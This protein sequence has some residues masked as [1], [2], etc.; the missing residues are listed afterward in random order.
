[1]D[2]TAHVTAIRGALEDVAG[3]GEA[4]QA[5]AGRMAAALAPALQLQLLDLLGEV[6]LEVSQQLPDGHVDL[7]LAGRDVL[8]VYRAE[9][10]AET[11]APLDGSET[12]RLTLRMPDSLKSAIEAAADADGIS[13][14]AWLVAAARRRLS[15]TPGATNHPV[16]TGRRITGY[17]QA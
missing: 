9:P 16:S 3:E 15:P 13:T 5:M 2:I 17:V 4:Q 6:A 7:Q 8:L 1:M 14:N 12:A 10:A 11:P